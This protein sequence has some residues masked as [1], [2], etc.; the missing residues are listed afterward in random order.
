MALPYRYLDLGKDLGLTV[1]R[2]LGWRFRVCE[3]IGLEASN[4]LHL[5]PAAFV[6]FVCSV[7]SR[8][9]GMEKKVETTMASSF[10][11]LAFNVVRQE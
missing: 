8:D 6:V 7:V 9:Y 10:D 3:G 5:R 4:L 2:C 1:A 11:F